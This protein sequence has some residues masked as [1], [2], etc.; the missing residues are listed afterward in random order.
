MILLIS[1]CWVA[2][3]PGIYHHTQLRKLIFK[4]SEI[5]WFIC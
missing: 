4:T 1:A 3:I 5:F 2:G